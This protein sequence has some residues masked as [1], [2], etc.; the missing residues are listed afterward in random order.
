V[1]L[2]GFTTPGRAP[3][4]SGRRSSPS[5]STTPGDPSRA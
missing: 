4:T 1:G 2:N 5:T 3:S